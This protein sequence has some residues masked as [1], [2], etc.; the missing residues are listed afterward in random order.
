MSTTTECG[1]IEILS[2]LGFDAALTRV[3]EAIAAAGLSI[4]ARIDHAQAAAQ[5]GLAMPPTTVL[6]YGSPKGGTPVMLAAPY[7]AL[8]LPL[9]VLVREAGTGTSVSFHPI[10][11]VLLMAGVPDYLANTLDSAQRMVMEALQS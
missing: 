10:E 4:F 8:D 1:V 11:A 5:A 3:A 7:A 2:P 6:I 9:R